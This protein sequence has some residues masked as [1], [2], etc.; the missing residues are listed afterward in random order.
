MISDHLSRHALYR[1]VHPLF[2]PGFDWLLALDPAIADGR[3]SIVGDDLFAL[4]Q[5]YETTS[6]SEKNF[7][8]HRERIDIQYLIA[9]GETMRC[10]PMEGLTTKIAYDSDRDVMFFQ[11]PLHSSALACDPG[12]FAIFHPHDAHKGGCILGVPST[13]RKVVLKIRA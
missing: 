7:E 1:S 13:V 4:V 5:T 3:Y 11:E 9:G 2:A 10:T 8:A 12:S 6:P